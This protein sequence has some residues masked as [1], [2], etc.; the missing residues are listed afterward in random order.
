MT[1]DKI[2]AMLNKEAPKREPNGKREVESELLVP[3]TMAVIISGA[4]LAKA[5]NVIPANA[6][7]ISS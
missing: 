4:P 5:K 6:S 7:E 1:L 2:I 3:A